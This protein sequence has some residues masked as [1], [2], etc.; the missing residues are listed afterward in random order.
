MTCPD[1]LKIELCIFSIQ[2]P[3]GLL[4]SITT[5]H[6]SLATLLSFFSLYLILHEIPIVTRSARHVSSTLFHDA[7]AGASEVR[8]WSND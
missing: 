7:A 4:G 3:S 1:L 2:H 5:F 8:R 6:L